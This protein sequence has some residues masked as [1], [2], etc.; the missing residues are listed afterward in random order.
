MRLCRR[1]LEAQGILLR[2]V[3]RAS[4]FLFLNL[5]SVKWFSEISHPNVPQIRVCFVFGGEHNIARVLQAHSDI[6]IEQSS[7]SLCQVEDA[8]QVAR[9]RTVRQTIGYSVQQVAIDVVGQLWSEVIDDSLADVDW[10]SVRLSF[11]VCWF[12][13][14]DLRYSRIEV[15][16]RRTIKISSGRPL[17]NLHDPECRN[18]AAVCCN[19][20]FG[21]NLCWQLRRA[22]GCGRR[23]A[24]SLR[25]HPFKRE[26]DS[27]PRAAKV[28]RALVSLAQRQGILLDPVDPQD[29]LAFEE[30]PASS[31]DFDR[32]RLLLGIEYEGAFAQL[33]VPVDYRELFT[34]EDPV[35]S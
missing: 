17:A 11:P 6:S 15:L 8:A 9:A 34:L 7:I 25:L 12:G 23:D 32:L 18:G 28:L 10:Y 4:P 26:Q 35:S 16:R 13:H 24:I 2:Q 33:F 20:L 29:S 3:T 30:L 1:F 27:L 31:L 22:D 5:R 21:D 14:T 19:G